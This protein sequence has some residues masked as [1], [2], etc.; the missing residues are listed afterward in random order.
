VAHHWA[1]SHPFAVRVDTP[2]DR[3]RATRKVKRLPWLRLAKGGGR[4]PG[5]QDSE[6]HQI[7]NI[8]KSFHLNCP[9]F[10]AACIRLSWRARL[11]TFSGA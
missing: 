4:H 11:R 10:P 8:G 3:K 6:F 9:Q 1:A 5:N 2:I 7:L